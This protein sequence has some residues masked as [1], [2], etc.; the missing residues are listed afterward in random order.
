MNGQKQSDR[1]NTVIQQTDHQPDTTKM[2]S[3]SYVQVYRQ[4]DRQTGRQTDRYENNV[5]QNNVQIN[6][7]QLYKEYTANTV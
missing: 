2:A 7:A 5:L 1:H 6:K 4:V 3:Q